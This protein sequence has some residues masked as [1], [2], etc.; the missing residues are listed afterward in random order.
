MQPFP[1]LLSA[2]LLVSRC[3]CGRGTTVVKC[4][5]CR[6]V[7]GID[8]LG[9]LFFELNQWVRYDESVNAII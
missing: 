8:V 4:F 7:A 3:L 9:T 1:F 2:D 5:V 6:G